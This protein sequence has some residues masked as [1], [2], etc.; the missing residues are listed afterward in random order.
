MKPSEIR[1]L[2]RLQRPEWRPRHRRLRHC[3]HL[4]DIREL[5]RRRIPQPVFDYVEGGADDELSLARN[6]HAFERWDL[7]P[8]AAVDVATTSTATQLLGH[9]VA[10]PLICSPT[11]YTRMMHPDGEI[12]V[13]SAAARAGIPY[14]LSTVATT[15]IED[16]ARTGHPN[17]WFQ[18]YVWRDRGLTGDLVDRAWAAGY[19]VLEISIDVAVTGYRIRDVRNGLTIPPRLTAA[20]LLGI[21]RKPGYWTHMLRS[22]AIVFANAPPHLGA[23][24]GLTIENITAQFDPSVTWTDIAALRERWPGALLIKGTLTGD[25]VEAALAAGVDGVHLSNHGGRQLDRTIAPVDLVPE[26]RAAA[27]D[28][29]TIIVDS[30]IRHGTDLAVAIARGATAGAVGRAPLYGLMAAGAEG[31]GKVLGLIAQEFKRTLQL[32]GVTSPDELRD[33]GH[34]LIR[35]RPT[36]RQQPR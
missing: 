28:G 24:E 16:V 14:A 9:P 27:G 3:H 17:L 34:A 11:G 1:H 31:V 12:A 10:L 20:S 21:A 6:R 2:V 7:V 36:A 30:G 5:A 25:A 22:P 23:G 8:R 32:L 33:H 29:F 4:S 35:E 15:S 26:V 18:L 19:R 13:A